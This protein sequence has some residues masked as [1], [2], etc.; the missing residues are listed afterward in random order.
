MCVCLDK[1]RKI[2]FDPLAMAI[3]IISDKWNEGENMEKN[4]SIYF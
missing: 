2:L 4:D 1:N 3:S